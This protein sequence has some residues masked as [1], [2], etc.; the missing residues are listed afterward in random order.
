MSSSANLPIEDALPALTAALRNTPN[1]VLIAPPGAGKT[2][3]VPLALLDEPWASG[4]IL[5]LEPRRVAARAAAERMASVLGEKVG[6][7]VGYSIRN[8]SAMSAS[9]RIEVITEGILT[10]RLQRDP[11]LVGIAAVIFDEY[12]ERSIH[13]DLGLALCLDAQSALRDD[14]RLLVMSATLDG[15]AVCAMMGNAPTIRSE[16]RAYPVE[17]RW[18][19]A[20]WKKPNSPRDAFESAVAACVTRAMAEEQG[21]ALVFLPGVREIERVSGLLA[22]GAFDVRP[23]HGSLPFAAQRAAL[24][25]SSTGQ[26][27]IVLATAIAETS[28]TIEGVRIVV[29]GGLSRRALFDAG[30]GM[31]RL[32]TRRVSRASADQRRGRAGRTEP[33]VCYRLWTKG[34]EGGFAAADPPEIAEA[35][36][37]PLALDLAVWGIRD[38]SDLRWLDAPPDTAFAQALDLLRAL[39]A[40]GEDGQP[41]AHGKALAEMPLHPRLAHL[42]IKGR[43]AG[44]GH[45]AADLA[46]LLEERDPLRG[47][48][49]DLALRLEALHGGAPNADRA[50]LARIKDTAKRLRKGPSDSAKLSPGFLVALAYP[51]R[52]A[53]RRP[54]DA[55]RYVMAGGKGALFSDT[56]DRLAGEPYLAIAQL[57]GNPREAKLRLAASLSRAEIETLFGARIENLKTCAWNPRTRTVDARLQTRLGAIVLDDKPWKN[58]DSPSIAAAATDGV[59]NLGLGCLPW[60]G[61]AERFRN[62]ARWAREKGRADLPDWSDE[63]LLQ[64]LD[65]WLSKH[66]SGVRKEADFAALDLVSIL[67]G[68]LDWDG[69]QTLDRL[70]P[71]SLQTPAGTKAKIDYAQDPPALE[72]RIQEMFGETRHPTICNGDVPLL[73]RFLSPARRPVQVT[74]DLPGFWASSYA[75]VRKDMRGK[76]PRHPWPEDPTIADPTSRVK[77]RKR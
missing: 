21:D 57:D 2:T 34:E 72:V 13:A 3:G 39:D 41:T 35:D 19:D 60:S 26:R 22:G 46:A 37:A 66:L 1:A 8:E 15:E 14:L 24:H 4:R 63:A 6:Q 58:A 47:A 17:T 33:G 31:T 23:I 68:M 56:G 36:L 67:T 48:G 76:Y 27:R 44:A 77:P 18:L 9:T 5:M 74:G 45:K 12:H 32:V 10:R 62:R 73:I 30:A 75:D 70:A 61:A 29:D 49:A 28:L 71:S 55:P 25:P 11:A 69:L 42:L 54:G 43:E 7:R 64:T 65:H 20:P 51:D 52:V 16:G 38:P 50:A 59:R 40:L 53:K